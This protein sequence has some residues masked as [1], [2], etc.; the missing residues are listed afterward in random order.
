MAEILSPPASSTMNLLLALVALF[1]LLTSAVL[2]TRQV[3]RRLLRKAWRELAPRLE[4][5]LTDGKRLSGRYKGMPLE[6]L[7]TGGSSQLRMAV[8]AELPPGLHL[9]RQAP[10][11]RRLLRVRDIQVG[12]KPLDDAVLIQSEH[13]AATIRLLRN[14]TVRDALLEFLS[15][16]P[17][18]VVTGNEVVVPLETRPDE[19]FGRRVLRSQQRLAAAI[20]SSAGHLQE[21]TL[22]AREQARLEGGQPTASQPL[23]HRPLQVPSG[24]SLRSLR[25]TFATRRW[26]HRLISY[27]PIII[28]L[29]MMGVSTF[30]LARPW[31]FPGVSL[32]LLG[33]VCHNIGGYFLLRCPACGGALIKATGGKAASFETEI[34]P[35]CQFRLT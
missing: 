34:C 26:I 9:S 30:Q 7:L 3:R 24:S 19:E 35:H 27:P 25:E 14:P 13:P 28:S 20:E 5:S 8:Q 22:V 11:A 32:I 21:Q 18:A 2:V 29:V 1:V 15:E 10:G 33:V 17:K 4:L 16:H 31:L 23:A 6:V 12:D